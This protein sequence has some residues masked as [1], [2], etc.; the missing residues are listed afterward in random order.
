M[1]NRLIASS[2]P[3]W[4]LL[5]GRLSAVVGSA[6]TVMAVEMAVKKVA[7]MVAT[8]VNSHRRAAI[9]G[10]SS[11]VA[12]QSASHC[13]SEG[14]RWLGKSVGNRKSLDGQTKATDAEPSERSDAAYR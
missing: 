8:A 1:A 12:N 2:S 9:G 11:A 5:T 3:S 7:I 4:V 14:S 13:G 6:G 10:R